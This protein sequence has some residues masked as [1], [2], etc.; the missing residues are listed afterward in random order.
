MQTVRTVMNVF[1]ECVLTVKSPN[2][3]NRLRDRIPDANRFGILKL[4]ISI[5]ASIASG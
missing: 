4:R 3:F 5:E 1:N 2:G